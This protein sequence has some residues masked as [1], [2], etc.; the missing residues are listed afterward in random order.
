MKNNRR[1]SERISIPL[2]ILLESASGN[3]ESRI[4]DLSRGGCFVDSIANVSHGEALAV[5]L[6]LPAGKSLRLIS[7]VVYLYPGFGFGLRFIAL[8]S[9]EQTLLEQVIKAHG[10]K[11][12]LQNLAVANETG[13]VKTITS[14]NESSPNTKSPTYY[15]FEQFI[16]DLMGNFEGEINLV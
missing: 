6:R 15:E 9:Y 7:E 14:M 12:S 13:T 8:T 1:Q 10:G 5:T 3:H 11:P 16:D 2:E 4:S